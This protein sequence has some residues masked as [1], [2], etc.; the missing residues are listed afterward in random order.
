MARRLHTGKTRDLKSVP[1]GASSPVYNRVTEMGTA[2]QMK[3]T[4]AKSGGVRSV[5][6]TKARV[7]GLYAG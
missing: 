4:P 1:G 2:P 5:R 3:M 7:S 6:R